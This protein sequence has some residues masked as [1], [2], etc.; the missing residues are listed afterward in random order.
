MS[1]RFLE[2]RVN[3]KFCVKLGKNTSDTCAV[4]SEA[5][6]GEAIKNLF[7]S[8][9]I[10][11][12][13]VT[14]TWKMIKTMHITFSSIK[15][16]VHFE[17]IPQGQTVSQAYYMCVVKGLN[18]GP[19][20]GFPTMTTPPAHRALSVKQFLAQKSITEMSSDLDPN[21]FCFQK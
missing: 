13:R 10:G 8:V 19:T 3:I 21:N 6:G 1:D 15:G 9:I 12:D 2:Q 17:F 4:L 18:F 11:S 20:I 14:R 5:Y 7:L 16:I